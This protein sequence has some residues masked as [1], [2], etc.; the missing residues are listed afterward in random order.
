MKTCSPCQKNAVLSVGEV[1]CD[2][3][4]KR[5]GK[6]D[7]YGLSK[8]VETGRLSISGYISKLEAK[9]NSHEKEHLEELKKVL[10]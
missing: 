2:S 4:K 6:M 3:I 1:I 10:G 8:K 9:A 5:D 7:C